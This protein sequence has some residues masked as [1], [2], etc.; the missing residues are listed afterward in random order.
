MLL[1]GEAIHAVSVGGFE[2]CIE[3][4][5]WKLCFD[6]GRCPPTAI[7]LPSVLF[8][9]AHTDHM[10]GVIHHCATRDLM[11]MPPPR[12]WIPAE[13]LD[14]FRAL[15]EVWRRLDR[16]ALP[17]TVHPVRPGDRIDLGGGRWARAFRALHRVPALGY[18][19]GVTRRKLRA[20]LVGAPK[21]E[22]I[23]RREAGEVIHEEREVVEIAFCGDTTIEVV[24]REPMVRHARILLLE[25][26]FLDDRVSVERSRN[27]GHIHLD[28]VLERADLFQNEAILITHVSARYGNQEAHDILRRRLPPTLRDR[29]SVLAHPPRNT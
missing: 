29:V 24:E 27:K 28:E 1:H 11:G 12:Y 5:R 3:L 8:T 4:P 6:I 19:L 10:G 15:L 18:A 14:A 9:H 7:R 26:T 22:I 16:S 23:G 25:V 20:D 21:E 17:C 2:T 13:D